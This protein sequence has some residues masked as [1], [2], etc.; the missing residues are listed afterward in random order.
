MNKWN[1]VLLA[2]YN[3]SQASFW[4]LD[5]KS[6]L[7]IVYSNPNVVEW[8]VP[9]NTHTHLSWHKDVT[10]LSWLFFSARAQEITTTRRSLYNFQQLKCRYKYSANCSSPPGFMPS[11]KFPVLI[12]QIFETGFQ[13]FFGR[14]FGFFFFSPPRPSASYQDIRI[15]ACT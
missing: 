15:T 14:C 3:C 1:K 7:Y 4:G 10:F 5:W 11:S 2:T 9:L 6:F 13:L 8:N 12:S